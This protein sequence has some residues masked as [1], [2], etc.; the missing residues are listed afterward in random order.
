MRFANT[1]AYG[2]QHLYTKFIFKI[3]LV[4]LSMAKLF[5]ESS[6]ISH[7]QFLY[8]MKK[9]PFVKFENMSINR[10]IHFYLLF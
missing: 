1:R 6:L 5:T 7:K 9:M 8:I 3:E 2:S 4:D 10:Q